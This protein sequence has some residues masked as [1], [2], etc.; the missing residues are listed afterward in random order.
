MVTF[1]LF[2]RRWLSLAMLACPTTLARPLPGAEPPRPEADVIAAWERAGA[3]F[4]WL[5]RMP[6]FVGIES[7]A[8]W[9][10]FKIGMEHITRWERMAVV[11]DVDWIKH[12]MRF[13]S[14]LMPGE[15]RTFARSESE[16][17]RA[18]IIGK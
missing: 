4:G 5:V 13:F 12:T 14:F 3:T 8:V 9:K 10:D 15:M 17:A 11:T 7:G 1:A 2:P 6:D 16:Q 18:W